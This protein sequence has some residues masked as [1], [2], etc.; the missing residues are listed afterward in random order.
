VTRE[1]VEKHQILRLVTGSHA[2]GLNGPDSDIDEKAIVI[3]PIAEVCGIGHPWEGKVYSQAGKEDFE[4]YG[5][6]KYLR[7]ALKGNPTVTEMLFIKGGTRDA[8]GSKLQELAPLIVS[9]Q[10]G[11]AYLGYMQAQRKRLMGERGNAG[12]GAPRQDLIEKYGFDTKFAMHMLRLG[13]QGIELLSNG[14]LQ[15][16]VRDDVR[17]YLLEVRQGA[18]RLDLCLK[19]TEELEAELKGLLQTAPIQEFSQVEAV[20]RWMLDMYFY[21]WS[22]MRSAE[23]AGK[24]F[25]G[26]DLIEAARA[27]GH[28]VVLQ[29]ISPV[30]DSVQIGAKQYGLEG[31]GQDGV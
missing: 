31:T 27:A 14:T 28:R 29:R 26:W 18:V 21:N 17:N 4:V 13:F 1:E 5:L 7:L 20:E 23:D 22:G 19:R 15:L 6:R 3:E 10:A 8:R 16:P 2:Y 9:R 25:I 30:R 12:H 24:P 11:K